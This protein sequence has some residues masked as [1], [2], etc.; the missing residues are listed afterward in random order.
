MDRRHSKLERRLKTLSVAHMYDVRNHD[1]Y[2]KHPKRVLTVD[3]L[4]RA[5]KVTS[6]QEQVRVAPPPR[7]A[8]HQHDH[9]RRA[10]DRRVRGRCASVPAQ[11][12]E[13]EG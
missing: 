13:E 5:V 8:V 2:V 9:N 12:E 7:H 4:R 11:P 3:E 1:K 6:F 10:R